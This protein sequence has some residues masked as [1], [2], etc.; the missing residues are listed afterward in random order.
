M[1]AALP[2]WLKWIVKY[3]ERAASEAIR[4]GEDTRD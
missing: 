2:Q 1:F 4:T 3:T